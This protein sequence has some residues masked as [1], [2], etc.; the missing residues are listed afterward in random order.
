[1]LFVTVW[2]L[3][4]TAAGPNKGDL[5]VTIMNII[6]TVGFVWV[7][8]IHMIQKG[9]LSIVHGPDYIQFN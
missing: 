4:R 5:L 3:P 1:M 9:A 7:Y 2:F 6:M 8:S